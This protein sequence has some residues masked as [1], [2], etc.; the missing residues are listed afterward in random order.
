MSIAASRD[1][2]RQK[3]HSRLR[4]TLTGRLSRGGYGRDLGFYIARLLQE[5]GE[6]P[7][8]LTRGYGRRDRVAAGPAR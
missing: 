8:I 2:S 3:R 4:L 6:R 7:A 1:A 5:N